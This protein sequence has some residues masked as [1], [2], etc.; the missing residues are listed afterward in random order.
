MTSWAAPELERIESDDHMGIASR[1]PDGSLRPYITVW[2]VRA[3][4]D[5]YVRSAY[6]PQNGWYVRARAAGEGRVRVGS[7]EH[8]V[9]FEVPDDPSLDAQLHRAY[10]VKY[11]RFGAAIV[12]TVISDEAARCTLRLVP[13]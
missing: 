10:H 7:A 6:G 13:L 12:G 4:D 11:D 1:R 2:F 9:T 8:D 3:G 5:L